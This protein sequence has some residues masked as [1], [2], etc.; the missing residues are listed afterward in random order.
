MA[1]PVGLPRLRV[2]ALIVIAAATAH[3]L[4]IF[5]DGTPTLASPYPLPLTVL[6]F[7]GVPVILLAAAFGGL[8]YL[9]S[10]R[11]GPNRARLGWGAVVGLLI[12][13]LASA[14]DFTSGWSNGL[15][16]QGAHFVVGSLAVSTTLVVG[17]ILLLIRNRSRPTP[18]T[19]LAFYILLFAWLGTYAM[20]YLGE[21]P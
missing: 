12:A 19:A 2:M 5:G 21:G 16:Y 20:P 15:T 10:C 14:G 13:A 6:M 8:F 4:G 9:A 11:V 18:I 1:M 17:L 7:F 3:S